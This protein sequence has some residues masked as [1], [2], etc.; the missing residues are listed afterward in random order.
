MSDQLLAEV[1]LDTVEFSV[2]EGRAAI[3]GL[4]IKQA[5]E[6]QSELPALKIKQFSVKIDPHSLITDE[7]IIDEI[8][9]QGGISYIASSLR[10]CLTSAHG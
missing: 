6:F 1:E 3:H 7:L 5:E 9:L 8:N 10:C 2:L 4:V